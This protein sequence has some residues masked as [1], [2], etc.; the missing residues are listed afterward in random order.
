[1]PGE[2]PGA[3]DHRPRRQ[4]QARPPSR[5]PRC[6]RASSCRAPAARSAGRGRAARPGPSPRP[7]TRRGSRAPCSARCTRRGPADAAWARRR[8]RPRA[9]SRPGGCDSSVTDGRVYRPRSRRPGRVRADEAIGGVPGGEADLPVAGEAVLREG[10][11][12][13]L[14]P[15]PV[16]ARERVAPAPSSGRSRPR[17]GPPE[18]AACARPRAPRASR[19]GLPATGG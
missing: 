14:Q 18:G 2:V 3:R 15:Q 1:M 7:G 19:H 12:R 8:R 16:R 6:A 10:L 9:R 17:A 11:R 4:A 13:V 5:A